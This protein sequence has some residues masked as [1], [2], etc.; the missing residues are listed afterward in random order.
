VLTDARSYSLWVVGAKDIRDVEGPWPQPGSRFHHTLG[1]GPFTLQDN[2]KSLKAEE[3][4]FLAIEARA[5]PLGRAHVTFTLARVDDGTRVTI[6]EM[7]VSPLVV[8]LFNPLLAPL[9][10]SRNVETLRRLA[11]VVRTSAAT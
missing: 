2:T 4:R 7:F 8:K 9:I 6:D 10:S 11:S 5:R 3:G 1:M